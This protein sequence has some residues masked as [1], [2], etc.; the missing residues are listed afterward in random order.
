MSKTTKYINHN[1]IKDCGWNPYGQEVG[2]SCYTY[3]KFVKTRDLLGFG[4]MMAVRTTD[5]LRYDFETKI[6]II[7]SDSP[8][9][10][11]IEFKTIIH[12]KSELL[13]IMNKINIKP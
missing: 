12:N 8:P 5:I 11:G 6:A 3:H 1:D 7:M 4:G 2:S 13:D 9:F 10:T